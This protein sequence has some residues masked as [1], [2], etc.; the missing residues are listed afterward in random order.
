MTSE[1]KTLQYKYCIKKMFHRRQNGAFRGL[2][3][4]GTPENRTQLLGLTKD[5]G[6]EDRSGHQPRNHSQN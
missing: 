3:I 2:F 1:Y 6:F 5:N 4:A